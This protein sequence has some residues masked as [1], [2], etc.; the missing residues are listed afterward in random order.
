MNEQEKRHG[1]DPYL[2]WVK[3][4]GLPAAEGYAVDLFAVETAPWAR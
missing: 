4:E 2:D 1:I 3:K